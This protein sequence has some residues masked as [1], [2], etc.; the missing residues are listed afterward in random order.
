MARRVEIVRHSPA[1][2]AEIRG[3]DLTQLLDDETFAA[4]HRAFLDY[5]VIFLRNQSLTPHQLLDF[6]SQEALLH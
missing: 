4:I 3:V 1:L 6:A 5:Q 2:G